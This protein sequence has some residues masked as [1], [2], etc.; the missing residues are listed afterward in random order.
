MDS[1]S[2]IIKNRPEIATSLMRT[3]ALDIIEAGILRVLPSQVMQASL[4][5]HQQ[6]RSLTVGGTHFDLSG[7]RVFVIG[8]G[9]AAAMM[10]GTL[11]SILGDDIIT[12]GI[13]TTKDGSVNYR[14]NRIEVVTADHPLPDQ[15]GIDGVRRMLTLKTDYRVGLNDTVICLISGGGSSLLPYPVDGIDLTAKQAV[16]SLLLAS[17]ADISE[18]N[19][20]RKHLSAI[21]GG[22]LGRYF[23]PAAVISLILSDV[24]G[25]DLSVIASGP[26]YPDRST[27]SDALTVLRKYNLIERSP[28]NM[29][30]LLQRGAAGLI[31]ETP[32]SL[33]N[34]H[35]F[36]VGDINLALTSMKEKAV[37][38]GLS[39]VVVTSAQKGDTNA[40]AS[41]RATEILDEKYTGYNTVILGGETTPTLPPH[42]GQ[43]GRNQHYAA[44]SMLFM[45]AY[46]G[47]WTVVSIGTDGSDYLPDIAGAIVDDDTLTHLG[48][49]NI[50]AKAYLDRFDSY[51]LLDIAGNSLV[52][53]GNTGT[54][55]G[56]V[57]VYILS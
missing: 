40:V 10:A 51:N 43:G 11:E 41:S 19:T 22:R 48:S 44:A 1:N 12:A 25:N 9:K 4:E 27:F 15:R 36:I 26:T 35:N 39:P 34:C 8:G 32:K 50:D 52:K 42:A 54:N 29:V 57:M 18:V 56:D 5:Y 20:V 53:T 37:K 13:V 14:T 16:T 46:S 23:A 24:I 31:E 21:K 33:D 30:A 49:R 6:S 47:H 45:R 3:Q 7:G 28:A 17:G 38:L 2:T 55:V